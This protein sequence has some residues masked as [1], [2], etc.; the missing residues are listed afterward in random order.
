MCFPVGHGAEKPKEVK[1]KTVPPYCMGHPSTTLP[2]ASLTHILRLSLIAALLMCFADI[3]WSLDPGKALTQYAHRV[4]RDKEGLP[5]NSVQA[6]AQTRDGYIWVGT[7]EGLARFDGISFTIFDRSNTPALRNNY[8]YALRED[9]DGTLWIG[10]NGGGLTRLKHGKF[11]TYTT[12]NGL[13]DDVVLSIA[14]DAGGDIWLGT[15]KGVTILRGETLLAFKGHPSLADERVMAVLPDRDGG[16]WFGT[17]ENGLGRWH[18]GSFSRMTTAQGLSHNSIWSLFQDR[19]GAL[20]VGTVGGGLNRLQAGQVTK[21]TAK[22]GLNSDNVFGTLEDRAGNLWIATDGG[23]LVRYQGGKFTSLTNAQ[24]LS[25]DTT[26]PLLEDR[27]G[28][29]WVGTLG[30]LNQ[31]RDTLF[32]PFGVTEGLPE[33][34]ILTVSEDRSGA[35]WMGG[36]GKGLSRLK[37]GK[38]TVFTRADGLPHDSVRS[39]YPDRAGNVWVG[40]I[41]GLG[42]LSNGRFRNY[43]EVDGLS[44]LKIAAIHEDPDGVIWVGTFGGG[45]NRMEGGRFT[46]F[47]RGDGL[48]GDRVLVITDRR[49]GG[50]WIG[51]DG[52]GLSLYHNGKFTNYTTR[53]G[54]V[55]D[56]IEALYEDAEGTLWIG[57]GGGGLGRFRDGR[58]TTFTTRH[59]LFDNLGHQILEDGMGYLWISTNRGIQRVS[60]RTL[61]NVAAGR[62]ASVQATLFGVGEGLR[63]R[64]ANGASQPAGWRGADGRLWF[65][66]MNGVVAVAP[67]RAGGKLSEPQALIES[68]TTNGVGIAAI[69]PNQGPGRGSLVFRYTALEFNNP[70]GLRFRY[71]LESFDEDWINAGERRSAYYTNIPPG[72]YRFRV[73]AASGGGPWGPPVATMAFDLLPRWYQTV[74]FKGLAA[75][76][77]LALLAAAH[78]LRSRQ[79]RR[80]THEL[81]ALVRERERAEDEVRRLNADLENRVAERTAELEAANREMESFSYSVSHD[82]RAPL[83]AIDGFSSMLL[84]THGEKLDERGRTMMGRIRAASQRMSNLI[85]DQL[86]LSGV[87]R[88]PISRTQFDFTGLSRKIATTTGQSLG[89]EKVSL[90]IQEQMTCYADLTLMEIAMGNLIENAW[91]YTSKT[92][93]PL[94]RIGAQRRG[95]TIEYFVADNG[96]G[97]DM[98]HADKLFSPFH[99][100]HSATDFPGTGIGLTIVQRIIHRH[101]GDIRAESKPG[102]GASFIFTV[103]DDLDIATE[104]QT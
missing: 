54:L 83:L 97:F 30:G 81:T 2:S 1:G 48:A 101:G 95:R 93:S 61:D 19:A 38:L 31:L 69:A 72:K 66:T 100:L 16:V 98:A 42:R 6:I 4:W 17:S 58:F 27:Q 56:H 24:G 29:L 37:D 47:K 62:A 63:S 103:G 32:T 68:A 13:A 21:F 35:L 41:A 82:L 88:R 71:Q 64:E 45:L 18:Q 11:T 7:Q 90:E 49:A 43:S 84:Q 78:L 91:K 59:G 65:P 15:G 46:S 20:W 53:D 23:G 99:R 55:D 60:K 33:E 80:R 73:S 67:E 39:V 102:E 34:V 89:H 10:T 92:E 26:W 12:A 79:L 40:T 57:T 75:V 85:D 25:N 51:T 3:S 77:T 8:I 86:R 87:S 5:Q 94:I 96:A 104:P 74:W 28:I 76:A 70:E 36:N 52:D 14:Q 9:R 44:N 50:L 22:D